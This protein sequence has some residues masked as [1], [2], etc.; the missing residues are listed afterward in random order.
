MIMLCNTVFFLSK[1][2]LFFYRMVGSWRSAGM[3]RRGWA[4]GV[5]GLRR[6][7]RQF[8]VRDLIT[9]DVVHENSHIKYF[10]SLVV[11]EGL[12]FFKEYCYHSIPDFSRF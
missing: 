12:L 3:G 2:L 1:N 6:T 4:L 5:C 11:S 8:A 10:K 7:G 9:A